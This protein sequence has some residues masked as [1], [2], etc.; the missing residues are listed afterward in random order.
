L[1]CSEVIMQASQ[2]NP[3][4]LPSEANNRRAVSR[5]AL[6]IRVDLFPLL[7][8]E[9]KPLSGCLR[10]GVT[11]DVSEQ[12]LL[13]GQAGLLSLG[14]TVRLFIRLPDLPADPIA[15]NARVVRCDRTGPPRYGLKFIGMRP[16]DIHRIQ[17][18]PRSAAP[19][20]KG[21]LS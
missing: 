2:A 5:H 20:E 16:T 8:E 11:M 19:A 3:P 1:A 7:D 10:C 21:A 12:G 13:F 6:N 15:C 9:K 18:F 14:S 4:P 17:S